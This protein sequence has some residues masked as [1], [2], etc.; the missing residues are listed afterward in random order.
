MWV[1]SEFQRHLGRGGVSYIFKRW[2]LARC[3]AHRAVGDAQVFA[4]AAVAQIEG[5]APYEVGCEASREHNH[6][7]W[8]PLPHGAGSMRKCELL[9]GIACIK[10][11]SEAGTHHAAEGSHAQ[12]ELQIEFANAGEFLLMRQFFL[13]GNTGRSCEQN[14]E[15]ANSHADKDDDTRA[16]RQELDEL[17]M[18][19]W[20]H[21]RAED[22]GVSKRHG[23]TE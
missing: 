4:V 22:G 2:M 21:Q 14:A 3:P 1:R 5:G 7:H 19:D 9:Y 18:K 8:K 13:F 23:H 16:L 17:A 11:E 10:S 20:R 12:A 15:H 6:E